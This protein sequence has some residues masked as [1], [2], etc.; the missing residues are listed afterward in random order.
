MQSCLGA[1]TTIFT[2]LRIA[3]CEMLLALDPL[4]GNKW[5]AAIRANAV[6]IT[7]AIDFAYVKERVLTKSKRDLH[8]RVLMFI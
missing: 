3:V 4:L 8:T 7:S 1:T 6:A 5:A 2:V